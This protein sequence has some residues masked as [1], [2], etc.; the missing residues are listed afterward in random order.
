MKT[1]DLKTAYRIVIEYLCNGGS[2][3]AADTL[4]FAAA[5]ARGIG[6]IV[7]IEKCADIW[8]EH[9]RIKA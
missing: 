2:I 8:I 4:I 9:I 3:P 7:T 5:Y 6:D 1:E